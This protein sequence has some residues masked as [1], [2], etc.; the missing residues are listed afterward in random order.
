MKRMLVHGETFLSVKWMRSVIPVPPTTNPAI[1]SARTH[2]FLAA[3]KTAPENAVPPRAIS[4]QNP[5]L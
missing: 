3:M 5:T 2:V 4:R 1:T